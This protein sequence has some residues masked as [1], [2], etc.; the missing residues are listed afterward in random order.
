M[1]DLQ[2]LE[3]EFNKLEESTCE[4]HESQIVCI[5]GSY[6]FDVFM[7]LRKSGIQISTG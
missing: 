1:F 2:D 6:K 5:S 7:P 4:K 3:V